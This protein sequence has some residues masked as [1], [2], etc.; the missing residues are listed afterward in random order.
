VKDGIS[1][2]THL[3]NGYF[4]EKYHLPISG[5]SDDDL[6]QA[7]NQKELSEESMSR[8][9]D[10]YTKANLVKFAGEAVED[11]EFHRLYDTIELVL[12]NQKSFKTEEDK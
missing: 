8:I 10:F 12:E 11:A 4:S 1:D 3:M 7:L 2:L 9:R 6:F 5:L